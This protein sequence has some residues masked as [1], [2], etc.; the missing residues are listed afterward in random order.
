MTSSSWSQTFARAGCLPFLALVARS[1]VSGSPVDER[2]YSVKIPARVLASLKSPHSMG[3]GAS[4]RSGVTRT[5][6]LTP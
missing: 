6:P 4:P 3:H 1:R 5:R 2:Q